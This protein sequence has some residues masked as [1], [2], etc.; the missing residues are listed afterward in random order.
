MPFREKVPLKDLYTKAG[1][2]TLDLLENMLKFNPQKRY[3]AEQCLAHPYFKGLHDKS[4][5]IESGVIFDWNFDRF[6][7]ESKE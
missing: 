1:P 3:S 6:E 7:C 4:K 5:E 2:S